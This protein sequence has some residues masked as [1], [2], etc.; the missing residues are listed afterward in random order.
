VR[1][2]RQQHYSTSSSPNP[3]SKA[4]YDRI[5][6][7]LPKGYWAVLQTI[8]PNASGW[9]RDKVVKYCNKVV[10]DRRRTERQRRKQWQLG[11]QDGN[12]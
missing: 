11:A 12:L 4:N 8:E 1:Q 10:R 6:V 5:C 2:Q 3:A 7:L 9:I